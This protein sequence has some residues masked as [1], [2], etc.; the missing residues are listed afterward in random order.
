MSPEPG[1]LG[2]VRCRTEMYFVFGGGGGKSIIRTLYVPHL[3]YIHNVLST[4]LFVYI[5]MCINLGYAKSD[6]KRLLCLR[7]NEDGNRVVIGVSY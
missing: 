6:P 3:H 2:R 7:I 5:C 1:S 4:I